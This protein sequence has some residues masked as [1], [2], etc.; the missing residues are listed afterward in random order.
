MKVSIAGHQF[1]VRTDASPKYIKDLAAYVTDKIDEAKASGR[2]VTTQSLALL[3][4][5]SIADELHQLR[6]SQERLKRQIR[7]KSKKILHYLDT[8]AEL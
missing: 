8:K 4:A 7:E 2:T 1:S 6:H 5:M 3:A